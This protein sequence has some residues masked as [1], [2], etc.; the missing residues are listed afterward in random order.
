MINRDFSELFKRTEVDDAADFAFDVLK[1]LNNDI[2][3]MPTS[4]Q[5][6]LR[7]YLAQGILDNGGLQY[8]FESNFEDCPPYSVFVDAYV[9]V[10][11]ADAAKLLDQAVAMFNDPDAHL[12]A[13]AR[14]AVMESLWNDPS[15]GFADLDLKLCGYES[16][17]D[18][19]RQ[20]VLSHRDEFGL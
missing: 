7:V 9:T 19:L 1:S 2:S 11:A 8:F 15:E 18:D 6:F 5:T 4:L 3:C 17:W 14:Q 10:G 16:V 20:F 13:N 12:D